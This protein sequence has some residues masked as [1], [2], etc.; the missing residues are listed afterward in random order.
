MQRASEV[1][2]ERTDEQAT[3]RMSALQVTYKKQELGQ[4]SLERQ[5]H[6]IGL[7]GRDKRATVGHVC[8]EC[9]GLVHL[10]F[11]VRMKF[12]LTQPTSYSRSFV[13]PSQVN[14][15]LL[16]LKATYPRLLFLNHPHLDRRRRAGPTP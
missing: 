11:F 14:N 7:R 4:S 3:T 12:M 9:A 15:T 2:N 10:F 8:Y 6:I 13:P 16:L 5:R 1:A